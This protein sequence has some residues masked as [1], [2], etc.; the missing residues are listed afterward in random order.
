MGLDE[1]VWQN[2]VA[3]ALLGTERQP[4]TVPIATGTLGQFLAQIPCQSPE[5]ALL[6]TA[7]VLSLYHQ[8]GWQPQT[9]PAL[10]QEP[11]APDDL[12]HC[13]RAA[14]FLQQMFQ[15]QYAEVLP[16]WLAI[17]ATTQQRVP[18]QYLPELLNLGKQRRDLRTAILPVLGQRGRWLAAQNSDWGY[19]IAV[20][21][22]EAWET[23]NLAARLLSLQDLR[24]HD[25]DRARALLQ[26]TWSQ[27]SADH[28][29]KFLETCRV[30]LSQADE[31]FLQ[32]ALG[33]RSK[34]VRRVAANLL[35]SLPDSHLCQQVVEHTCRYLVVERSPVLSLQ[36]QLPTQLDQT[37]M[38]L[39]MEPKPSAS[40][41]SR[42]GE[43][44]WWLLQMI[45]ATPLSTWSDRWQ[46]SPQ[47]IVKLTQSHEWQ[48][49]LL[50]GFALAAKR[51][52]NYDWLA[53][54]FELWLTGQASPRDA[55]LTD[56][57]LE[58]LFN[59]FPSEYRDAL[60]VKLL[61]FSPERISESLTLWLLRYNAHQWSLD[62]TRI[63]LDSLEHHLNR[64][65]TLTNTDWELRT[66][67][68]EFA[69]FIPV[70]MMAESI[71]L[72]LQLDPQSP[73]LHSIEEFLAL[74]QFRLE[75]TQAFA[76]VTQE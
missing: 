56:L 6:V 48:M 63:V 11:A 70:S 30:G 74:L 53:A 8:A 68:K 76:P 23:G 22:A 71:K 15:G 18:A 25:P 36:V 44:A 32:E 28:R 1:S 66:A 73:W 13:M 21:T 5:A 33:D 27:E 64:A 38:Q 3:V 72:K 47:A 4:F 31:P 67:L 69:R 7:A 52:K 39:G 14:R 26:A 62:L 20:A 75:M 16:E 35:A 43:R 60:L 24:S 2:V 17:A 55:A 57:S 9:Y 58:D 10:T 40:V 29:A 37:L 61:Q 50:D 59:V 42:L 34:E 12:P 46:L 41:N 51:Q 45:G 19:A 65:N 54:I 49:V